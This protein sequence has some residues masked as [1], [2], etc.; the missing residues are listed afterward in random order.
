MSSYVSHHSSQPPTT[1]PPLTAVLAEL[2]AEPRS[3]ADTPTYLLDIIVAQC[4]PILKLF[5][6]K[7]QT[8]LIRRDALFV[9]DLGL[10]I[11]DC[12]A[13]FDFEGDGFAREGLDEAGS[14]ETVSALAPMD[15]EDEEEEMERVRI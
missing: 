5:S 14:G 1:S 10:D 15:R 3:K 6:R 9:L 13:G 7:D 8:L 4:P 2:L 12:V 11:V